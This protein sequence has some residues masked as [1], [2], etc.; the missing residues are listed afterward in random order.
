MTY[1]PTLPALSGAGRRQG[2]APAAKRL[3]RWTRRLAVGLTVL[4][5][6][7][8]VLLAPSNAD[9]AS[10]GTLALSP[11]HSASASVAGSF[12]DATGSATITVPSARPAYFALQ[13]RATDAGKGY[14]TR[15]RILEDG[16]VWVGF[17]RVTGGK[18][19]LLLSKATGV[20]VSAGQKLTI[21]GSV[22]GSNPVALSVRAWVAGSTKPGWQQTYKDTSS[23]RITAAGPVRLWGYLSGAASGFA[24][25][26]FSG[27]TAGGVSTT[28]R[29]APTTGTS[30][31]GKPS[32][33]T[34]GVPTGT[35]LTAHYGNITVTKDGTVLDRMDIHGFVNVKAKNVRITNSIVRGGKANGTATG[36][37]TDYGYAGLVIENVDVK[38]EYPSVYF[39]GIKGNNF[40]ARR[41]H[42][43]GNVDSVKIHGDN[44]TVENSLLE[45]TTKYASDP[46][47]GGSATHNDNIQI[48]YGRNLNIRGNTIRGATNFA[49]LGAA[50]RGNTPNLV[51]TG[52]WLDGGHCTVKLQVLNGWS[53]TATVKDNKFGPN[54]VIKNCQLQVYT[55]VHLTASGNVMELTG[56][57]VSPLRDN[58]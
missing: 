39:D 40:I 17:S 6:G 16:T 8:A 49:I 19:T 48:L 10:T 27:A 54:R 9:A 31:I 47:Q 57:A 35:S 12:A 55:A 53:E 29:P 43:Q 22:T 18:E 3:A 58:S 52:N 37:I 46:A 32:A 56:A 23:A 5:A 44:V 51:V 1:Q 2:A 33:S 42:V 36:L 11:G 30:A 25:V 38:A 50:S 34:T 28:P 26:A 45:N 21:E 7:V 20:K 24:S 15:A 13:F 4:S 41:V 14:R